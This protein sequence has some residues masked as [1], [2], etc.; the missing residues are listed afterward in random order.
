MVE[1]VDGSYIAQL[2]VTDMTIPIQYA[3]TYPERKQSGLFEK[4]DFFKLGQLNFLNL[5]L[6]SFHVL[7]WHMKL[8]LRH[9]PCQRFLMPLMSRQLACFFRKK[10]NCRYSLC[11]WK[12]NGDASNRK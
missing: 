4:I 10:L 6:K 9:I 3:L 5:I 7:S 2:N 8:R 11:N 1:Y 12:S